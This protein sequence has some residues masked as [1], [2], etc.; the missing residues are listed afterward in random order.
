M[1][2]LIKVLPLVVTTAACCLCFGHTLSFAIHPHMDKGSEAIR[3]EFERLLPTAAKGGFL[4]SSD[5]HTPP[6][7]SYQ[8]YKSYLSLFKEY[9]EWAGAMSQKIV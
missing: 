5:H 4:V 2:K 8:D 9:A 3:K 6:G 7:V 1:E